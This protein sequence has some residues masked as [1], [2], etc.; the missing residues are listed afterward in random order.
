MNTSSKILMIFWVWQQKI[1]AADTFNPAHHSKRC[2]WVYKQK[3]TK[4]L[5]TE[6]VF[7]EKIWINPLFKYLEV[8]SKESKRIF[9]FDKF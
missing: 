7:E 4:L 2:L 5:I 1:I 9:D 8:A 3:I 6:H